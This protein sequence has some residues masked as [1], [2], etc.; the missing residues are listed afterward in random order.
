[1]INR[2]CKVSGLT[3]YTKRDVFTIA[4]QA[5]L[6]L[7]GFMKI[8]AAH[9]LCCDSNVVLFLLENEAVIVHSTVDGRV[10]SLTHYIPSLGPALD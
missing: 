6:Q 1:M 9:N 10:G 5:R 7:S 3:I 2:V 4:L 8:L